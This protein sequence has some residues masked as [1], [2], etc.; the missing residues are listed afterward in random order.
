MM[1][2]MYIATDDQKELKIPPWKAVL[3][4]LP[5]F[6]AQKNVKLIRPSFTNN[7]VMLS[8]LGITQQ[9]G[10]TLLCSMHYNLKDQS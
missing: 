5:S 8:T 10:P 2:I 7:S 3:Q 1:A 4:L 6:L 9:L